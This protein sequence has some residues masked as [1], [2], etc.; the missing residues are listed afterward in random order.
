MGNK[1][2][3]FILSYLRNRKHRVKIGSYMSK[4][5][6]ILL[7][8]PQGSILGPILF[9]IFI[10]DLLLYLEGYDIC[11]FADDNTISVYG[12]TEKEVITKLENSCKTALEWFSNNYLVANPNK[13]QI[14]FIQ[15]ERATAFIK[16]KI[17]DKIVE[18][19]ETVTLL[20]YLILLG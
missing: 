20:G 19:T 17:Q 14:I 1:S 12:K 16:I 15:K 9:N 5:L 4:W 6:S 2:L 3:R 10:N 11:N 13:F 8:V 7:G 18:S